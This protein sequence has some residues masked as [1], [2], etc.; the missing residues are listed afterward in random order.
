[1]ISKKTHRILN[2]VSAA[3]VLVGMLFLAIAIAR[4]C[5]DKPDEPLTTAVYIIYEENGNLRSSQIYALS[6]ASVYREPPEIPLDDGWYEQIAQMVAGKAGDKMFT[7]QTQVA[8]VIYNDLVDC[9]WN[10]Q[11]AIDTYDL[12]ERKNPNEK[13]YEAVNQIFL[14]GE[15]MLDPEVLWFNDKDH[16]SEFHDSLVYVCETDGIAF[17]RAHWPAVV[18]E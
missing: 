13:T 18:P 15:W 14:R 4:A 16:P 6:E 7:C 3:L 5:E 11:G 17:Y 8:N 1:M 12:Y 10:M 9:G 2:A